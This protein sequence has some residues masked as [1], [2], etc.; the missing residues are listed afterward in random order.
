MMTSSALT[1]RRR[2]DPEPLISPVMTIFA[3][4]IL[5]MEIADSSLTFPDK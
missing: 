5:P 2:L 1:L 4:S 3:P